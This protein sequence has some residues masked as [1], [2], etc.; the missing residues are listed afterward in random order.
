[1]R[2]FECCACNKIQVQTTNDFIFL[3]DASLMVAE[4]L[5]I[6]NKSR[7]KG[8]SGR[9]LPTRKKTE[10]NDQQSKSINFSNPFEAGFKKKL[11]KCLIQNKKP[12]EP[13]PEVDL[14]LVGKLNQ[15]EF[16]RVWFFKVPT[17]PSLSAEAVNFNEKKVVETVGESESDNNNFIK[18]IEVEEGSE[19]DD[20]NS[21]IESEKLKSRKKFLKNCI[22][23]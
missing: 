15:A 14:N 18:K 19:K 10:E 17:N 12:L 9:K 11:S 1:M 23:L 16:N 13:E 2:C 7:A 4:N 6:P 8:P 3:Q 21:S 5:N 20:I 22:I